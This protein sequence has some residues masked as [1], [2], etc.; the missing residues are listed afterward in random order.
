MIAG[1]DFFF[2]F[3]FIFHARWR[4]SNNSE[5]DDNGIESDKKER[6]RESM[7]HNEEWGVAHRKRE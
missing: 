5:G 1:M 3:L 4:V 6:E 7:G 2:S